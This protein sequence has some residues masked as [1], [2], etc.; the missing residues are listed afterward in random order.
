[1]IRLSFKFSIITLGLPI[2]DSGL[3][4][5][6]LIC[7]VLIGLAKLL[8][9][10]ALFTRQFFALALQL[11]CDDRYMQQ[12]NKDQVQRNEDLKSGGGPLL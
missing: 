9:M 5:G 3:E 11:E 4:L 6:V 1:M 2:V 12:N 8:L 7:D 10:H